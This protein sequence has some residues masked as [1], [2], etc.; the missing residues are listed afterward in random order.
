MS[1]YNYNTNQWNTITVKQKYTGVTA[2]MGGQVPVKIS[3][4]FLIP[5]FK[6]FAG[7]GLGQNSFF[8]FIYGYKFGVEVA[9]KLNTKSYL[10]GGLEFKKNCFS[11]DKG[12][13]D[14]S[15]P[16]FPSLDLYFGISF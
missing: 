6:G 4:I 2:N 7:V 1:D 16:S 11:Y 12:F 14:Y 8:R 5:Y 10:L 15:I 3:N 13:D 9:H